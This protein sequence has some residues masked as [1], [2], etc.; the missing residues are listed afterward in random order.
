MKGKEGSRDPEAREAKSGLASSRRV[1][2]T[3]SVKH[4][5]ADA[6]PYLFGAPGGSNNA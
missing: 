6:S 5:F 3:S 2:D 1:L 4:Y